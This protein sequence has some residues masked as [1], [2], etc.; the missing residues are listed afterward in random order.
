MAEWTTQ[1]PVKSI[2]QSTSQE[3]SLAYQD[4]GDSYAYGDDG[5]VIGV[6]VTPG[7]SKLDLGLD[8]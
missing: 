8:E 5:E 3:E 2:W 4:L 6:N 7:G 1:V